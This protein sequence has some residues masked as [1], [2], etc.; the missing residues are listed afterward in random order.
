MTKI[1]DDR[2]AVKPTL[3]GDYVAGGLKTKFNKFE[4]SC[5]G[6]NAAPLHH[7]LLAFDCID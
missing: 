3:S 7:S 2:I 1:I 5:C 6:F 4:F